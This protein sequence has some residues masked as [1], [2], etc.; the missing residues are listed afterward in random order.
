MSAVLRSAGRRQSLHKRVGIYSTTSNGRGFYALAKIPSASIYS[1][2]A[3]KAD[4]KFFPRV[5]S[6]G[7]SKDNAVNSGNFW[8]I[9][10][11]QSSPGIT[12]NQILDNS[13]LAF[14]TGGEVPWF[15]QSELS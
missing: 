5:V 8:G 10:L 4:Y 15:G 12:I 11:V 2:L 13:S 3:S 9:D 6:I 14:S 7:T 1:I